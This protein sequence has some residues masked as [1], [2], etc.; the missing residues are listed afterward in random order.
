MALMRFKNQNR[1]LQAIREYRQDLALALHYAKTAEDRGQRLAWWDTVERCQ[2]ELC[3][4]NAYI[5]P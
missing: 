2:N 1:V 5:T 4:L 3:D